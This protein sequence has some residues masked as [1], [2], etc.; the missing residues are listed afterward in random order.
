[1]R[2]REDHSRSHRA[3]ADRL[4]EAFVT[5]AADIAEQIDSRALEELLIAHR[6]WSAWLREGRV[7]KIAVVA[8]KLE[9]TRTGSG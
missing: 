3:I 7:R 5:D 1:V 9:A 8:E 2:W 6:L 4:I